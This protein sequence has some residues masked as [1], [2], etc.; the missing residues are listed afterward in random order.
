MLKLRS[1]LTCSYC[2]KIFRDPIFLP[3]DDSICLEHLSEREVLKA[4]EIKCNKCNE[5]FQVK[6]NDFKSNTYLKNS[7][8]NQSYLSREEQSLKQELEESIRQFFQFCEELIQNKSKL[9]S[10]V[11]DHFQEMRFQVDEHREE[12]KKKIDEIALAMID[13]IKKSEESFSKSLKEKL[14]SSLDHS[15]SLQIKLNEIEDTFRNPHLL[16]QTIQAIQ[17]NQEDSLKDIQIKLNQ[18]NQVNDQ[19]KATNVFKPNLSLLNQEEETCL[20]GLIKL[21]GYWLNFNPFNSE[22]LNGERQCSE[23]IDACQFSPSDKWSLLYRSTRDGLS[24]NDF[25]SRCDGH[26]NTLTI[27]KAK[28][29]KFIFGGFT[30]VS[31]DS[32]SEDKSDP[33]AFIFSLT[34]G[35][36]QPVKIDIHPNRHRRAIYCHSSWGPTFGED[37]S[38]V[39]NDNNATM[40]S[41]SQLGASYPHPQYKCITDEAQTFLAGSHRFKLDEI[42]VYQKE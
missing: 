3:C 4:N 38:L 25:H 39:K 18:M 42:E 36:N 23:L 34:N 24:T 35:D 17:Q 7:I 12:L 30:S 16:I 8:E 32:F 1:K 40:D 41:Y 19:L 20:F 28:G 5:E 29:S 11:F 33:N 9:D 10:N 15:Q 13:K 14:S 26:S 31:W 6:N 2:S 22:I 37:I 27:L 21:D